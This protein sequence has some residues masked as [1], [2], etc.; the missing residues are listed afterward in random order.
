MPRRA[1]HEEYNAPWQVGVG[2]GGG[3]TEGQGGRE[4]VMGICDRHQSWK[5]PLTSDTQPVLLWSSI[6]SLSPHSS[7]LEWCYILCH[8]MLEVYNLEW[9]FILCHSVGSM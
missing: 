1:T 5:M 8:S 9:H 2:W 3:G 6:S 4:G 7:L